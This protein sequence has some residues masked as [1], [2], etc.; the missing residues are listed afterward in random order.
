MPLVTDGDLNISFY[1]RASANTAITNVYAAID[2][3][4]LATATP[5][6]VLVT[7]APSDWNAVSS[8]IVP[9]F[10]DYTDN[11]IIATSSAPFTQQKLFVAWSDGRLGV[12]QPFNANTPTS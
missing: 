10:G 1:G 8:Y 4:P 5:G 9:N 12:P 3:S 7:T 2:V 11:Y 6:N